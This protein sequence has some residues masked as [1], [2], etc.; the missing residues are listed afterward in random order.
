MA[1]IN[2]QMLDDD[3]VHADVIVTLAD[4]AR[5]ESGD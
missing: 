4:W 3:V 1:T 2:V 5:A